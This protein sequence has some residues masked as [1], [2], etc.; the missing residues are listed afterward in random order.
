MP[1][2]PQLDG[3]TVRF[4]ALPSLVDLRRSTMQVF[5]VALI[6]A[7]VSPCAIAWRLPVACIEA[8][9][10]SWF[11]PVR[12]DVE[13]ASTIV[14][15]VEGEISSGEIKRRDSAHG[16]YAGSLWN[17]TH[18]ACFRYDQ[19][20]NNQRPLWNSQFGNQFF[21]WVLSSV[22]FFCWVGQ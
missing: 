21:F 10:P 11:L 15:A 6:F 1:C 5:E 4:T 20:F 9:V 19:R 22:P 17:F 16:H 3:G 12:S 18:S 7:N 13:C 14:N 8:T 2:P